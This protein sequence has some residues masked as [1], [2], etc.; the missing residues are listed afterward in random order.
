V[1][2]ATANVAKLMAAYLL[3]LALGIPAG[4]LALGVGVAATTH[5]VFGA[6][7]GFIGAFVLKRLANSGVVTIET[8]GSEP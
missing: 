6:L 2:A 5:V 4:Y 1:A 8:S 7:G 3:G